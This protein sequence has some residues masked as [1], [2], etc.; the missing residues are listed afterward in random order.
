MFGFGKCKTPVD[1]T[2]QRVIVTGGFRNFRTWEG[3][4]CGVLPGEELQ[5]S[6]RSSEKIIGK[7]ESA[8]MAPDPTFL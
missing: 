2:D 6:S 5:L 3:G 8:S 7:G 4:L 1:F